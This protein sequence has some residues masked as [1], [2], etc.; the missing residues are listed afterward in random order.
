LGFFNATSL[1]KKLKKLKKLKQILFE[2]FLCKNNIAI[3]AK[4]EAAKINNSK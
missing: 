4:A 2:L 3:F 1:I